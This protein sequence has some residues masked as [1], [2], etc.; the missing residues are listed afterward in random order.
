[1]EAV[2]VVDVDVQT[3]LDNVALD[4][5]HRDPADRTI[6]ALAKRRGAPLVT[7]DAAIRDFY[8]DTVW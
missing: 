5:R 3:W 8:A 2:E 7:A 4:W 6:V 1:M